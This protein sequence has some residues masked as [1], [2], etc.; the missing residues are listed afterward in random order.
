M[1]S[2]LK[3]HNKVNVLKVLFF[4]LLVFPFITHIYSAVFPIIYNFEIAYISLVLGTILLIITIHNPL[5]AVQRDIVYFLP[6]LVVSLLISIHNHNFMVIKYLTY[7][8]IYMYLFRRILLEKYIFKLYVNILVVTFIVL[9]VIYILTICF[10]LYKYF[11]IEDLAHLIPNSPM[12]QTAHRSQ[13]FY[14]LVYDYYDVSGILNVPRFYGF[15]REP[16]FYVMFIIPAFFMAYFFTMKAQMIILAFA[17]FITSSF[18]GYSVVLILLF[19]SLISKKMFIPAVIFSIAAF[20]FLKDYL[21]L[22]DVE[23]VDDALKLFD[24]IVSRYSVNI[25][26][27]DSL[28]FI[29]HKLSF[30]L[31]IYN[32]YKKL[33]TIDSKVMFLFFLAF[34]VLISK[35]N[36]ILSPLFLFYLIF[37][38][39]VYKNKVIEH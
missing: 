10:D 32:V 5:I 35:A 14:L 12:N 3:V 2:K 33:V 38:D 22:L 36:E 8:I 1:S 26:N 27:Y 16:G 23:R 34:I 11:L 30:L 31:I 19:F 39:Y 21:Y 28:L 20:I 6:F 37:I 29:S 24:Q 7:I 18:A 15:S 4:V 25:Q 17:I 13:I 9:L